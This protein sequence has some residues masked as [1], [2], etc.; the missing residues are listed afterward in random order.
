MIN[1]VFLI[2]TYIFTLNITTKTIYNKINLNKNIYNIISNKNRSNEN[3]FNFSNINK[4]NKDNQIYNLSLINK[5]INSSI[6]YSSNIVKKRKNLLIG[7]ISNYNWEVLEPFFKSFNQSNFKNCDC[8]MFINN[9][10]LETQNKIKYFGVIVK[11]ISQEKFKNIKLINYRWK[12]YEDFLIN[13]YDKY[14]MIFTADLRDVFFQ[15]DVFKYYHNNKSFLGVAIEDDTLSQIINKGWIINAYGN[16]IFK[17]IENERIICV[18]T[19]WGTIDKFIEFSKIMWEVLSSEWSIRKDVVEQAVANYLIYHEKMFNDCLVISDNRNGPVMTIGITMK[20]QLNLNNDNNILNGKGEIAAVIH[21][22]DRKQYIVDKVKNKYSDIIKNNTLNN[23]INNLSFIVKFNNNSNYNKK[24]N[25]KSNNSYERIN[26]NTL[27][28][29]FIWDN[30]NNSN[31]NNNKYDNSL[32]YNI[33]IF[34]FI[35]FRNIFLIFI[36]IIIFLIIYLYKYQYFYKSKNKYEILDSSSFH[37]VKC[38]KIN[39]ETK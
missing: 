16:D 28:R 36:L 29:N 18:G 24:L 32:N 38:I 19:I 8:I 10:S 30:F 21:Q 20:G 39:K 4:I 5:N 37:I 13:N 6:I 35:T 22:Y 26:I 15:K 33:K 25:N 3:Y 1:F 23:N 11:E 27:Y 31:R 9:I 7:A 14:D 12:L 2:F 34:R 17:S